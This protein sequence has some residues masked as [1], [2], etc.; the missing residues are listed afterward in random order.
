MTLSQFRSQLVQHLSPLYQPEEANSLVRRLLVAHFQTNWAQL[1]LLLSHELEPDAEASLLIQVSRLKSG[2][3]IQ[4]VLG[5]E[6]FANRVFRVGPGV[7]IPRPETEELV[8][9]ARELMNGMPKPV[10]LDA[11]TGSG[12]IAITLALELPQARVF[13]LD[14]SPVA[15]EVAVS[16]AQQL[17]AS[18]EFSRLDI[19]MEV[20]ALP[21]VNLLV[22][23][24]PYV[25]QSDAG[26]MHPNVINYEPHS[27]LFAPGPDP[28]V[29]YK[30]LVELAPN[31]IEQSG[32]LLVELPSDQAVAVTTIAESGPFSRIEIRRDAFGR[33]RML[34]AQLA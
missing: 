16:N 10:V 3:P 7:L 8:I 18:V 28:L 22:S 30:R 23:N 20:P 32:W 1:P 17:G 14:V 33:W 29:F 24:P 11:G 13:A 27:A 26:T 34:A 2:E 5:Y 19:L 9:W 12:C 15:L 25:S 21:R 4:Y 31:L 6:T